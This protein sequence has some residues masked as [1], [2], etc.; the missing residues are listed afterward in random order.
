MAR[1]HQVCEECRPVPR[2]EI[3]AWYGWADVLVLPT[4]SDTFGLVILEAMS[5]GVPVITTHASGGPD[6][7]RDGV[8]GWLV[9]LRDPT[10]IA[11]RLDTL[12]RTPD[13]ATDMG[14]SALERSAE[15]DSATYRRRL[16]EAI[17]S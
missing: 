15:F 9:P 13:L 14:R 2:S 17:T 12:M 10:A 6:V 3:H 11:H 4:L 5:S 1:V 8:D 7:I 16:L